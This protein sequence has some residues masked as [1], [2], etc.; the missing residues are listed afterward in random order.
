LNERIA[1]PPKLPDQL[2]RLEVFSPH[3]LLCMDETVCEIFM[4]MLGIE[5]HP[6][7]GGLKS[8]DPDADPDQTA[9]IGF[10][11][12]ISGL[13]EIRLSLPASIIVT[14]AML[15]GIDVTEQT[16]LICD[17]IGELCN[18]VAGGWKDRLPE[19]SHSCSL[20]I[21]TVI[22][23]EMYRVHL[24][25][26]TLINRRAYCF[27]DHHVLQITLVYDASGT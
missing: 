6:C 23:G 11:G 8:A 1:M 5:I 13:C 22:E 16:E 2:R 14:S 15:G 12:V 19:L 3:N 20:T 25:A 17:A 10:A 7:A 26:D 18:L 21:P 4:V 9:I 27:G 24:P